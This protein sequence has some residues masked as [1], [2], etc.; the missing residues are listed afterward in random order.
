[1]ARALIEATIASH[2]TAE[3]QDAH[4]VKQSYTSRIDSFLAVIFAMLAL[5][6]VIALIGIGNTVQLSVHE[7][8]RE[9]GLLRAVGASR[10]QL[11]S[12][13]RW[14]ASLISVIGTVAGVGL[15]VAFSWAIIH[16]LGRD[17]R[18]LYTVP[19]RQVIGF[20]ALGA[21]AGVVASLRPSARAGRLD[22][23]G[24][25]AAE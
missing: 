25:I 17:D 24:A 8:T 4:D 16:G 20:V 3:V 11:R 18:L 7:R 19:I 13:V 9:L 14:E 1:M 10:G 12:M 22:I 23:L 6:I 15:G 5:A 21:V 2:P